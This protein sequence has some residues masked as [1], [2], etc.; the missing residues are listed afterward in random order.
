MLVCVLGNLG[1]YTT[2]ML[3]QRY[4]L[5]KDQVASK[6]AVM[7]IVSIVF[8]ALA[9]ILG[10]ILSDKLRKQKVFV[11]G[12]SAVFIIALLIEALAPNFNVFLIGACIGS[13]AYG[14]FICVDQALMVRILPNKEDAGKD[15]AII[16]LPS[17][18][19]TPTV[20]FISPLILSFT[21]WTGYFYIFA[22]VAALSIFTIMPIPEMSPKTEEEKIAL[23]A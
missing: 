1:T 7:S 6:V 13:F 16:G 23:E 22:V 12:S 11:I 8:L 5:D 17:G 15:M 21:S 2:I 10:G 3:L 4:G 20:S 14:V 9:S 18:L 19:A